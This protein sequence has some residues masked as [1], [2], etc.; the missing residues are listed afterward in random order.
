MTHWGYEGPQAP[1]HWSSLDPGFAVCGYGREQSP[2]DLTGAER[3]A[4]SEIRFEYAPSPISM[5]NNGHSIQVDYQAGSGIV[6]DGTRYELAQFHFHHRSE[7]TVDGA[8]FPLE[9]HLVHA[10]ADG[11]LA[12]VGVFLEEGGANEALA[13]VWRHVPAEAGPA[14]LVA[15]T[16]DAAALLP[17]RRTTWRYRGSLTTPPCSEGVS[18]LM[19]TE[20]VTA[21]REQIEAFRALFPVNN[22]PVQ[23]LNGRRL[24]TDAG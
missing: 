23:P 6:L 22:R 8:D 7:H 4:L 10:D 1:E 3:E 18:W 9:L 24:V 12:V 15:G 21:S 2:I 13:P 5:Q 14:A 16:V 17:E 20:P 11:A 19:M